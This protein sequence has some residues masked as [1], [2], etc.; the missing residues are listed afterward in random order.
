MYLRTAFWRT[1]ALAAVGFHVEEACAMT[2][3]GPSRRGEHNHGLN[4]A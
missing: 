2:M 1:I 4:L 3:M